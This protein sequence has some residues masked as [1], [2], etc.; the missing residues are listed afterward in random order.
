MRTESM[1]LLNQDLPTPIDEIIERLQSAA[2]SSKANCGAFRAGA[3]SAR[4]CR[5]ELWG[6][7]HTNLNFGADDFRELPQELT[8][9][10]KMPAS[11]VSTLES[12]SR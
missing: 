9:I 11:L 12:E 7:R 4:D 5:L 2:S 10:G 3:Q 1:G 6:L 8:R